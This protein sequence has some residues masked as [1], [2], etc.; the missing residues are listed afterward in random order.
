MGKQLDSLADVVSFGVAPGLILYQL[1]R[2]SYAQ[3][4][5][6]LD[7]SMAWLLPAFLIPAAAA[8]R[9]AKFN[10]D[11]EQKSSFKGVPAPAVGLVIASFPL[12]MHFQTFNLQ[13]VFINRWLLYAIILLLSFFMISG[14]P[15]M[16][17]KIKDVKK[18]NNFSKFVLIALGFV[19]VINLKWFAAPVIFVL[20]I[21]VSSTEKYVEEKFSN[22]EGRYAMIVGILLVIANI[23]LISIFRSDFF[24]LDNP[25]I[26][27][28]HITS[29]ILRILIG[30]WIISISNQSGK[31]SIIWGIFGFLF[32]AITLI[33]IGLKN[34][35]QK[36][37]QTFS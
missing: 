17:L 22:L 5:N 31:N 19:A 16:S 27:M 8:W 13:F 6:G 29:L 35:N 4:E 1:L 21:L 28:I 25:T 33:I 3:E 32:P 20:Y 18:E 7:I 36:K 10:L 14:L 26:L 11:D 12:I 2:V 9:L 34:L 24:A 30:L 37:A 15:M 23:I